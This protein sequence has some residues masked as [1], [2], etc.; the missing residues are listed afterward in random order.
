MLCRDPTPNAKSLMTVEFKRA[1]FTF[2]VCSNCRH[3][4]VQLIYDRIP[5]E[6]DFVK[7]SI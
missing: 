2:H 3:K 7:V 1:D 6:Q 5:D 4:S